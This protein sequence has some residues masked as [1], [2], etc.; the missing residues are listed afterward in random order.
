MFS[1]TYR[2]ING[3]FSR[4][5]SGSFQNALNSCSSYYNSKGCIYLHMIREI[6]FQIFKNT[7]CML[8]FLLLKEELPTIAWTLW[9][10]NSHDEP[11]EGY[12]SHIISMGPMK[13]VYW[14]MGCM[15]LHVTSF[16]FRLIES[17]NTNHQKPSQ[18]TGCIVI[19]F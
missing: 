2:K 1:D 7:I 5:M 13:I 3:I 12:I 6:L 10:F 15:N 16:S 14:T 11:I 9:S 19:W 8:N 18:N 17:T 4:K